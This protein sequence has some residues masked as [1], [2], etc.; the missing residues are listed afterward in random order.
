MSCEMP[1]KFLKG[2]RKASWRSYFLHF[3]SLTFLETNA[4]HGEKCSLI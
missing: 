4:G 2:Q 3:M 1:G